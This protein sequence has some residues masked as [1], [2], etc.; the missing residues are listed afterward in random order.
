M[1]S[2]SLS[3]RAERILNRMAQV[4]AHEQDTGARNA[5]EQMKVRLRQQ[6][7]A[8][9]DLA[10]AELG[11]RERG[12]KILPVAE[13]V[14]R[15]VA[16]AKSALRTTADGLVGCSTKEIV[17]R[18]RAQ[19]VDHAVGLAERLAK[20]KTKSLNEAVDR[21]REQLLPSNIDGKIIHYP[22][23]SDALVARLTRVQRLLT[24]VVEQ[25]PVDD[26]AEHLD[27]IVSAVETWEQDRPLL[28]NELEKNHPEI[29]AFLREAAGDG[30]PWHLIT[31][32]V[33]EWLADPNN[34][35]DLKVVLRT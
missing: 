7:E 6:R 17:E 9:E 2:E 13:S 15:D 33:R 10:K 5:V 28:E 25:K 35:A 31:P 20:A 24:T 11:L 16:K 18:V 1:P 27:N 8:L 29:K 21:R 34:T 19:S 4:Q 32:R 26:L 12:V 22:G 30:A 23:V 14:T 3:T